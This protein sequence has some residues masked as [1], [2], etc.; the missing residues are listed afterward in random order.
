MTSLDALLATEI[1]LK[2]LTLQVVAVPNK[3]P[4][5]SAIGERRERRALLVRWTDR[6][7]AW[8]IGECSCR[9]DPFYNGEFVEGAISV[10]RDYIFPHLPG[11]GTARDV[12]AVAMKMRGW[13][14]TVAALLDA[15]FD[16]MR[17]KRLPDL[18]DGWPTPPQPRAVPWR[19]LGAA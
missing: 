5:R 13:N 7:D 18:W 12:A 4:F 3:E 11:Q 16:L 10:L 2:H 15:L 19:D 17:R 14:F 8:G 9:P 6:D 1:S